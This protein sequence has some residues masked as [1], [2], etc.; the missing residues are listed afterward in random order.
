M[1]VVRLFFHVIN[2]I[3]FWVPVGTARYWVRR[4]GLMWVRITYPRVWPYLA[5]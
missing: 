4:M 2:R 1:R 5:S 3:S